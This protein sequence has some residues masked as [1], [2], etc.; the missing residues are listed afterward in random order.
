MWDFKQTPSN[1]HK[2]RKSQM[3]LFPATLRNMKI[4]EPFIREDPHTVISSW[5]II[6]Y[7]TDAY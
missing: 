1:L 6:I 2:V 7:M 5:Q 4:S 3:N